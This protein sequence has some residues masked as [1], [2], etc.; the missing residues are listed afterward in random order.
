MTIKDIK[1]AEAAKI[2]TLEVKDTEFIEGMIIFNSNIGVIGEAK[3][4]LRATKSKSKNEKDIHINV[5][6]L[7]QNTKN[8]S[9]WWF[10]KRLDGNN[11]LGTT[12][13]FVLK[14]DEEKFQIKP[15]KETIQDFEIDVDATIKVNTA[16]LK[17]INTLHFNK[18]NPR[19]TKNF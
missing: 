15:D 7:W 14:Y 5:E 1:T 12:N 18:R 6:K 11:I 17:Y 10:T 16:Y 13:I 3:S 8:R 2:Q 19:R 9:N 4:G